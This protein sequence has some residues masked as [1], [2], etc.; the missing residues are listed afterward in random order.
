MSECVC[1]LSS[2]PA[3][4]AHAPYCY[5]WPARL[6]GIFPLYSI[7]GTIFEKKKKT[8]IEHKI[9]VG[10]SIKLLSET[11]LILRRNERDMINKIRI[12]G[13]RVKYLLFLSDF[14]ET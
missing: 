3:C 7:N 12:I 5:L 8:I 10:F 9:C 6:Y 1:L 11:F 2:H 13:L 14:N 4:N